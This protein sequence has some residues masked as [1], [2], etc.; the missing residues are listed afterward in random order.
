MDQVRHHEDDRTNKNITHFMWFCEER[1]RIRKAY[2][3]GEPRPYTDDPILHRHKF[4]NI[5]RRH[6]RGT[7]RLYIIATEGYEHEDSRYGAKFS[8][9]YL[10]RAVYA[11][12]LYRFTGS[13][14]HQQGM[15]EDN[16]VE[17]WY[18]LAHQVR[19]TF[20]MKSYQAAWPA[21]KGT[22]I[23]FVQHD[24][25]RLADQ[26]LGWLQISPQNTIQ[27]LSQQMSSMLRGMGYKS[28]RF[29]STEVA[30]D[31]SDLTD[32]VDP[33]SECPMGPGA[34]KG[35]K[36]IFGSEAVR[37]TKFLQTAT[38]WQPQVVE[39]ALCEYSKY[40]SYQSG[41]RSAES[42]VYTPHIL[43]YNNKQA[44]KQSNRGDKQ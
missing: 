31:L 34:R 27:S 10:R 39:H 41:E 13:N 5:D 22:G 38:Q 15:M 28:M 37:H 20:S 30:K 11:S 25:K 1:E 33:Q 35:L 42:K 26:L 17:R 4:T 7:K 19:P 44:Q 36:A 24:A 12:V 6:D 2:E 40:L 21:G 14:P 32:R 9:E 29:Q 23:K 18:E 16:P 3:A 43:L 8:P